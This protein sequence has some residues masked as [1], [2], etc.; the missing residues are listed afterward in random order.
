MEGPELEPLPCTPLESTLTRLVSCPA[1][2]PTRKRESKPTA[3]RSLPDPGWIAVSMVRLPW[4]HRLERARVSNRHGDPRA[5]TSA[6][7]AHSRECAPTSGSVRASLRLPPWS[8]SHHGR[9]PLQA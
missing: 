1:A 2:G 5:G 4:V 8:A 9:P 3:H 6:A 7:V